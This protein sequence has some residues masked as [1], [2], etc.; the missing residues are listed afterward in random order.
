[1]PRGMGVL[2]VKTWLKVS[3][4][5]QQTPLTSVQLLTAMRMAV[6]ATPKVATI[7]LSGQQHFYPRRLNHSR[8]PMYSLHVRGSIHQLCA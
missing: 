7:P 1:M 5:M 2:A 4:N 6:F 3:A 8:L